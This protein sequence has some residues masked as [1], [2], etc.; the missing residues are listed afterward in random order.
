MCSPIAK[1][2]VASVDSSRRDAILKGI[3]FVVAGLSLDK[4]EAYTSF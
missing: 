3:R 2:W 1:D 4:G